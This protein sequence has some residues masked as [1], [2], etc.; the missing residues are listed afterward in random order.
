MLCGRGYDKSSMPGGQEC[1]G[2]ERKRCE[3]KLKRCLG[4][5]LKKFLGWKM[6]ILYPNTFNTYASW[7]AGEC[8]VWEGYGNHSM[9]VGEVE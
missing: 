3:A 7:A 4:V 1:P 5:Q 6:Y 2:K 9:L 8:C